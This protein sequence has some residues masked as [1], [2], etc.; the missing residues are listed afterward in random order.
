MNHL[1]TRGW[2]WEDRLLATLFGSMY[3]GP[4]TWKA[5]GKDVLSGITTVWLN[6][7]QRTEIGGMK[8]SPKPVY[9][10]GDAS[11]TMFLWSQAW[12][13]PS[14]SQSW[15][16]AEGQGAATCTPSPT[17][18][19]GPRKLETKNWGGEPKEEA[20]ERFARHSG[21]DWALLFQ[22]QRV[23]CPLGSSG[24]PCQLVE[25]P[26]PSFRAEGRLHCTEHSHH[27]SGP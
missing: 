21:M 1:P 9:L 13:V 25:V 18:T 19:G 23:T 3:S 27:L 2:L 14:P 4:G 11:H 8:G 26:L 10:N 7:F 6:T 20:Q 5:L 16:A 15:A 17:Q 22:L 24:H 12:A